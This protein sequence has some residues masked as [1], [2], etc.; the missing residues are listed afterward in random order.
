MRPSSISILPIAVLSVLLA[1]P[2]VSRAQSGGRGFHPPQQVGAGGGAHAGML[3][4]SLPEIDAR[5][6]AMGLEGLEEWLMLYG[7][8][9]SLQ[10][11]HWQI[12]GAGY[13]GSTEQTVV[14]GETL[15]SAR[16]DLGYGGLTLGYVKAA[17]S[18]KLTLG[19]LLGIGSM[20]LTLRRTPEAPASWADLWE[21]YEA[22]SPPGPVDPGDL[23]LSTRLTGNWFAVEPFVDV[24]YWLVPLVAVELSAHYHLGSIGGGKLEQN[25]VAIPGSPELDLSGMGFRVGLFIGF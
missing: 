19:T 9:G 18:L 17:G 8:G 2:A 24:R 6:R 21:E 3:Q 1:L 11:G 25:G 20:E 22:G 13:G 10:R 7:G 16:L 14:S 15:R 12:G 5:L 4:V 23:R